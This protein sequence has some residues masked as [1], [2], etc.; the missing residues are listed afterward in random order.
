MALSDTGVRQART[1]GDD[2]TLIH[3]DGLAL[4]VAAKGAKSWHFRFSWASKVVAAE[5]TFEAVFQSWR[6]FKALSATHPSSPRSDL[7]ASQGTGW[8]ILDA[9]Y[10]S[11]L[12]RIARRLTYYDWQRGA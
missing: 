3:T 7:Q 11:F 2:Y 4:F 12:G 6:N 10:A 8:S 5:N 1:T 9:G